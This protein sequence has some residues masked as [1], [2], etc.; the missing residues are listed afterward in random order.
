MAGPQFKGRYFDGR[1]A[2]RHDVE[3]MIDSSGIHLSGGPFGEGEIWPFDAVRLLS[4]EHHDG[5]L[6][7]TRRDD[8]AVRL[9]VLG[10]GAWAAIENRAPGVKIAAAPTGLRT[11]LMISALILVLFGALYIAFP[12]FAGGAAALVPASVADKLGELVAGTIVAEEAVCTG[13]EGSR[14]LDAL[15]ADLGE[16]S[17][18]E[19]AIKASVVDH[20]MQNALAAPG[21]RIVVFRGLLAKAR[22]ADEVAGVIAHEM[23]HVKNRHP[24]KRLIEVF[25]LQLFLGSSNSD[26]GGLGGLL[27]ILSYGRADEAEA[28]ADAVAFLNAAGISVE[29]F[30]GFFERLG[31]GD[32][33]GGLIPGFLS[34]H[35]QHADRVAHIRAGARPGEKRPALSEEDWELLKQI[36]LAKAPKTD[37]E[38][39]DEPDDEVGDA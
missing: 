21:G 33:F 2:A 27:T 32:D 11:P 35:P 36:C 37:D 3:V 20:P 16:A 38:P 31:S 22:S 23:G 7:L 4:R 14:V 25:G 9:T 12:Y 5:G 8:G 34:T 24:L 19:L 18:A 15:I 13:A 1:S 30:A 29:D 39:D 10:T 28:D 17:G 6:T 26:I